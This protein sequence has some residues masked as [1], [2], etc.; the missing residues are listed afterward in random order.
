[1]TARFDPD[2]NPWHYIVLILDG[3]KRHVSDDELALIHEAIPLACAGPD[4]DRNAA[5]LAAFERFRRE[6]FEIDAQYPTR[7]DA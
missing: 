4:R 7:K 2:T 3:A 6:L 5:S 1:M